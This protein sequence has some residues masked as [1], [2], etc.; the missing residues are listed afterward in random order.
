[1]SITYTPDTSTI[2]DRLPGHDHG[3]PYACQ[4]VG[5]VTS[6][7]IWYGDNP[8]SFSLPLLLAQLSL[9]FAL[10]RFLHSLLKPLGQP[11]IVSQILAGIVLGPSVLGRT[12]SFGSTMFPSRGKSIF[13]TF[14]MFGF[15][16]SVFQIGVK[17]DLSIVLQSGRRSLAIGALSFFLPYTLANF[18]ALL[19]SQFLRLDRDTTE[20]VHLLASLL[21]MSAF[22][23]VACFLAELKILN[24]DIGRMASSSSL[25]CDVCH[26]SVLTGKYAVRLAMTKSLRISLGSLTSTALLIGAIVFGVRPAALWM[27]RHTPEEESVKEIYVFAVLVVLLICGFLA[28]AVG[29]SAFMASFILGLV[30]PDGPPLGATLVERLECFVSVLLMPIFFTTGGL[31]MDIFAIKS[32][33]NVT[34]MQLVVLVS[35]LGKFVGAILPPLILRMPIRDAVSLGLILNSKGI[36]ELGLLSSWKTTNVLNEECFA[37][38]ILSVV[39]VTGVVSPVVKLLYDPS[40]RYIAYKRRTILHH[41]QRE[42]LRVLACIHSEE[43]VQPTLNLLDATY[44]TETSPIDLCI[45]HLVKLAGRASSLLVSMPP[46]GAPVQNP[47]SSYRIFDAFRKFEQEM[48][49]LVKLRCYK[50]VSP[51]AT[52]HNDVCSLALEKRITLIIVPFHKQYGHWGMETSNPVRQLNRNVLLKAPCSVAVLIDRS[53][54]KRFYGSS[55]TESPIYRV[56]MLFFWGA[57]DREALAYSGRMLVRPNASLAVIRFAFSE[58]PAGWTARSKVLDIEMLNEYRRKAR[59]DGRVTF[60]EE[61]AMNGASVVDVFRSLEDVYDLVIVGRRHGESELMR[62]LEGCCQNE[63]QGVVGDSLASLGIQGGFLV[64]VVQQQTKVWGLHDP[65]ESTRLRKVRL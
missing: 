28:E 31:Q 64:L 37:V 39:V 36:I 61:A 16:L 22:P 7:G 10:T 20:A 2:G 1:M 4:S 27:I 59:E 56:A 54:R 52:M 11:S 48:Q 6:R 33:Q 47:T 62:E 32:L 8:L 44:P 42:P 29:L 24:S 5:H 38:M 43:N 65:E 51:Y 13:E 41:G 14:A 53:K 46:R 60:K 55:R 57:D 26:W 49:G 3:I 34:A 35:F 12:S 17:M 9:I 45:L 63:G 40:R 58:D 30:I 19:L 25:V 15:M 18:T 21:S 50:G 23:V